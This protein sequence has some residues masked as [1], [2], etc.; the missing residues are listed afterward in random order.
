MTIRAATPDD[1][2]ACAAVQVRSWQATYAGILPQEHIDRRT[3]EFRTAQW[4]ERLRAGEEDIFVACE[5]DGAI[6]GFTSGGR[7]V[8]AVEGFD[9]EIGTIYLLPEAQGKG[10]G[11]QLL[12]AL[13]AALQEKGFKAA[14]VRVLSDNAPA[15]RFYE[16]CG[17]EV[18][19]ETEE[20]I[21]GFIYREHFYGWRDLAKL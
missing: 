4:T 12:R 1:A 17:A 20:D 3:V 19:C 10:I 14:W 15:R 21:D 9:A 11:K 6:V 5:P 18:V 7:S 16:K 13:S 2:A 8:E